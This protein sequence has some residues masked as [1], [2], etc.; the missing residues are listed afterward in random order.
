MA[1]YPGAGVGGHCIPVDP[2]YMIEYA[3]SHGFHHDFLSLARR[4]NNAMPEF[5]VDQLI[6]A[7]NEKQRA[8]NGS[9]VAVLGLSYKPD[10]DDRRESPSYEIL[11]LLKLH[12]ATVRLFDP[13]VLDESDV[14]SLA[15]ALAGADAVVLATA[16]TAFKK[17]TPAQLEKAG[18]QVI[19]DGRNSLKKDQFVKSSVLYKG[20]GR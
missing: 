18:V 20:I 7:M 9:V 13:F 3:K 2:Y 4:I 8:L 11:K 14:K 19:I 10:I 17:I 15:D 16:H 6:A 5:T 12:G 1:H